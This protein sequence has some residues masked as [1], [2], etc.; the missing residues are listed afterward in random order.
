M[1][2][3]VALIAALVKIAAIVGYIMIA[4][5]MAVWLERKLVADIQARIGPNRVG[6]FGLLQAFA[7]GIKLLF[8]EAIT[9][10]EVDRLLYFAAPIV[11]MIPAFAVA[12]VVPFGPTLHAFGYDHKLVVAD[13]PVGVLFVLAVTSLSVYGIVLSG[14]SSNSKY[15]LLGGLRSSAQ[16]VSYELPMGLCAVAAVMIASWRF[17]EGHGFFSLSLAQ[18]VDAQQGWFWNWTAFNWRFGFLGLLAGLIFFI[19]GLA[20]TNRAPFDLPE[21]ESELVGGY[22]TEYTGMRF[23]LFFLAEYAAMMNVAASTTVLFFGGWRAIYPDPFPA[24]SVLSVLHGVLWFGAKIWFIMAVYI[25]IRGTLPRLRYDQLMEFG[26]KRLIPA[27]L[28]IVFVTAIVLT[29]VFP[30][31]PPAFLIQAAQASTPAP[32]GNAPAGNAPPVNLPGG[33]LSGNT[34][35]MGN[36]PA[37]N[38]PAAN[39][40]AGNLPAAVSPAGNAPGRTPAE[41]PS[42]P[43]NVPPPSNVPANAPVTTPHANSPAP[44]GGR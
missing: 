30:M 9:P 22:H 25:W 18:I 21:A 2:F 19:C 4:V 10:V 14:W 8:K 43:A 33:L 42:V 38:A 31:R 20:E 7:D 37:P 27:S 34:P 12:A 15:S 40:P 29:F 6:P 41:T 39:A 24:G 13:L 17:T 44:S 35:G 28:G 26:W 23:A 3:H 36:A 5:P 11:V 1:P 16:M 32:P